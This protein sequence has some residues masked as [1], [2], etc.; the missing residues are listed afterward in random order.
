LKQPSSTA[1]S[2]CP[3][4][5]ITSIKSRPVR[6]KIDDEKLLDATAE[7]CDAVDRAK[8]DKTVMAAKAKQ[9]TGAQND[10]AR[11]LKVWLQRAVNRAIRASHTGVPFPDE[12][13]AMG[14]LQSVP[15]LLDKSSKVLGLLA[16]NAATLAK[17]G[18]APAVSEPAPTPPAPASKPA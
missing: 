10:S 6:E 12:L 9:A 14:N 1:I 17:V 13:T 7:L 2:L 5:E 4:G 3:I 11:D 18:P 15:A 16:E 8:Q